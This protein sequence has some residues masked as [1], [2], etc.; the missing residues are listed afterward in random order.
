MAPDT[1]ST[2]AAARVFGYLSLLGKDDSETVRATFPL[3]GSV[4]T[5]GKGSACTIRLRGASN[6]VR[7]EVDTAT[8]KVGPCLVRRPRSGGGVG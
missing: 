6:V 5:I 4:C 8:H 3:E 2:K 1:P 7:I